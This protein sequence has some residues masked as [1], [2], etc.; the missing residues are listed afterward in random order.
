M[1]ISVMLLLLL[2]F[3]YSLCMEFQTRNNEVYPK[4]YVP[5]I[6]SN[7]FCLSLTT[8]KTL[9]KQNVYLEQCYIEKRAT[10]NLAQMKNKLAMLSLAYL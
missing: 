7:P 2:L 9:Y 8:A 1:W 6:C 5:G 4:I 10:G 3:Q